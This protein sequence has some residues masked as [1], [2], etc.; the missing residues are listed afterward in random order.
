VKWLATKLVVGC[1]C[2]LCGCSPFDLIPPQ[3]RDS[4]FI[5][6]AGEIE[7]LTE[8]E[9]QEVVTIVNARFQLYLAL[10]AVLPFEELTLPGCLSNIVQIDDA[11]QFELD[12]ACAKGEGVGEGTVVVLEE[13][14]STSDHD[15]LRFVVTY[16]GVRIGPLQVDGVEEVIETAGV[17]GTSVRKLKLV[18]DG[19][20]LNYQFRI[21][22]TEEESVFL[23][24][25]LAHRNGDLLA[26]ISDPTSAG[27]LATII[28]TGLDG[29][30]ACEIRNVDWTLGQVPKGY[31]ENGYTFGLPSNQ[32][33]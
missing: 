14:H 20:T 18:Q 1:L 28:L 3:F 31:C 16:K 13:D 19:V 30:L 32:L 22:L 6:P 2:L 12:V 23:D 24:Y 8:D 27:A 10:R 15:V 29:S 7:A 33:R 5:L 4:P 9:V 17:E 25:R 21:G 11:V 26:R